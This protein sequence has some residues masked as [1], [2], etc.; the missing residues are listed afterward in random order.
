MAIDAS[1]P[2]INSGADLVASRKLLEQMRLAANDGVVDETEI[3]DLQA[4]AE[5]DNGEGVSDE[6][7]Q[8][9]NSINVDKTDGKLVAENIKKLQS[10]TSSEAN[11]V[12]FSGLTLK[13]EQKST[14]NRFSFG[15]FG[16]KETISHNIRMQGQSTV[17]TGSAE[18]PVL[19]NPNTVTSMQDREPIERDNLNSLLGVMDNEL[20]QNTPEVRQRIAEAYNLTPDSPEVNSKIQSLRTEIAGLKSNPDQSVS[21]SSYQIRQLLNSYSS[22][23]PAEGS[24]MTADYMGRL[25]GAIDNVTDA[26]SMA[27]QEQQNIAKGN[28]QTPDTIEKANSQLQESDTK[29][30]AS[31]EK[32]VSSSENLVQAMETL[33]QKDPAAFKELMKGYSAADIQGLKDQVAQLK[34]NLASGEPLSPAQLNQANTL[35]GMVDQVDKSFSPAEKPASPEELNALREGIQHL[36]GTLTIFEPGSA[37]HQATTAELEGK[38]T[39]LAALEA[40]GS[41]S[42]SPES[43]KLTEAVRS[44]QSSAFS[45]VLDGYWDTREAVQDRSGM[46]SELTHAKSTL[47]QLIANPSLSAA[48]KETLQKQLNAVNQGLSSL[49]ESGDLSFTSDEQKQDFNKVLTSLHSMK[50]PPAT[51][52]IVTTR[53]PNM[54][55]ATNLSA[56]G[57]GLLP[58]STRIGTGNLSLT[59]NANNTMNSLGINTS[60]ATGYQPSYVDPMGSNAFNLGLDPTLDIGST[61]LSLGSNIPS[62][63]FNSG[64]GLYPSLYASDPLG[65]SDPFGFG[66]LYSPVGTS[67]LAYGG[68]GVC[69]PGMSTDFGFGSGYLTGGGSSAPAG[70]AQTRSLESIM[71]ES[72]GESHLAGSG[73]TAA[74]EPSDEVRNTINE[75]QTE[76]GAGKDASLT[77][78]ALA[79]GLSQAVDGPTSGVTVPIQIS[80]MTEKNPQAAAD[81]LTQYSSL[82]DKFGADFA[83]ES[84]E[85]VMNDKQMSLTD[86]AVILDKLSQSDKIA[87]AYTQA[88]S[89]GLN[90]GATLL[91]KEAVD[92]IKQL[93]E[94]T[95]SS[96]PNALTLDSVNARIEELAK[97]PTFAADSEHLAGG[98]ATASAQESQARSQ[99]IIKTGATSLV[100]DIA[101]KANITLTNGD[102]TPLITSTDPNVNELLRLSTNTALSGLHTA[103]SDMLSEAISNGYKNS[104]VTATTPLTAEQLSEISKHVS[105]DTLDSYKE[106]KASLIQ[107]N[108]ISFL[109]GSSQ[110]QIQAF[111][112]AAVRTRA[113][114]PGASEPSPEAQN[115]IEARAKIYDAAQIALQEKGYL[116][117][118]ENEA[119]TFASV[120]MPRAEAFFAN[121]ASHNSPNALNPFRAEYNTILNSGPPFT[122]AMSDNVISLI[123]RMENPENGLVQLSR[124]ERIEINTSGDKDVL[125]ALGTGVDGITNADGT[126]STAGTTNAD[127]TIST[128]G[129]TNADGTIST[130]GT[131]DNSGSVS[132]NLADNVEG[133]RETLNL[134]T[135]AYSRVAV[136]TI[137]AENLDP[138]IV[139]AAQFE[140]AAEY[141]EALN[142]RPP[143]PAASYTPSALDLSI[144]NSGSTDQA[145]FTATNNLGEPQRSQAF[146]SQLE[147]AIENI[148]I[149]T[150]LN[151]TMGEIAAQTLDYSINR[152]SDPGKYAVISQNQLTRLDAEGSRLAK[153]HAAVAQDVRNKSAIADDLEANN[154]LAPQGKNSETFLTDMIQSW[155]DTYNKYGVE[156]LAAQMSETINKAFTAALLAFYKDNGERRVEDLNE[157]LT[158][159]ADTYSKTV[160]QDLQSSS[161]ESAGSAQAIAALSVGSSDNKAGFN[162]AISAAGVREHLSGMI[163][164]AE[165]ISSARFPTQTKE[166]LVNQGELIMDIIQRIG[167]Q[168]AERDENREKVL[169]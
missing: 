101:G 116:T 147:R 106:A 46:V 137:P 93:P 39:Q 5:T 86:K 154:L 21:S 110:R 20:A 61:P 157:L 151:R 133:T 41:S 3:A 8:L 148:S 7:K 146:G 67:P 4:T 23:P 24:P 113:Q 80:Q 153:E 34:T 127:G 111:G 131:V 162:S 167:L 122:K 136:N 124:N 30:R 88:K 141:T 165:G 69:G 22:N 130:A 28:I 53:P 115:A 63:G 72:I 74:F 87:K 26:D 81:L 44:T 50:A 9:I 99:S 76:N 166:Q 17:N 56:G 109:R 71:L 100:S 59:G 66:G 54:A 149:G 84:L 161:L 75:L 123:A 138:E 140:T 38:R 168:N 27:S 95:D 105:A 79:A 114:T 152:E 160:S 73:D 142:N 164:A 40:K 90:F 120:T 51:A 126:I 12:D 37:E 83:N 15:L 68:S 89:D 70:S 107:L 77:A 134:A 82:K 43:Q 143:V 135:L 78:R 13:T 119:I 35:W 55:L 65:F 91:I 25:R 132:T 42:L 128:A 2:N 96:D 145:L 85:V 129:T 52:P 14:I 1:G 159:L 144:S 108:D 18:S 64:L 62:L 45:D 150:Q 163:D 48:G 121:S 33:N 31:L 125:V 156:A 10:Y 112:N 94:T 117:P 97:S 169:H 11:E 32:M 36:E 16:G 6:E 139:F 47:D 60:F 102:P 103:Q 92:G 118:T 104:A 58:G 49:R 155:Q 19:N 98:A 57:V 158:S 29:A